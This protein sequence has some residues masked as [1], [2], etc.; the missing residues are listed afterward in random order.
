MPANLRKIN[1][2]VEL[3]RFD[4]WQVWLFNFLL[5][6]ILFELPQI[7]RFAVILFAFILATSAIFILN[8]YFDQEND[9]V[10]NLK[11]NLPIASG[12]VTP[13]TGLTLFF[14]FTLVSLTSAFL[15]DISV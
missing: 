7:S 11:K 13:R 10:N 3:L 4:S 15:T 5:G 6:A 2:Y 14:A 8:Q 9:K 1:A 12:D